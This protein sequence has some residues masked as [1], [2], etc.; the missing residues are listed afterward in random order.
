MG[1]LAK[2]L[3]DCYNSRFDVTIRALG[4]EGAGIN[5]II[6]RVEGNEYHSKVNV[7]V[8]TVDDIVIAIYKKMFEHY[9]KS[10]AVKKWKQAGIHY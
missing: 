9:S 2:I 4:N 10:K 5:I 1:K 7:F 8:N 6:G 3:Q